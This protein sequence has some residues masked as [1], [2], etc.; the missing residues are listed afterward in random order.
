MYIHVHTGRDEK[1][2]KPKYTS[3]IIGDLYCHLY[4]SP[5][6]YICFGFYCFQIQKKEEK[7]G[8]ISTKERL[9]V[10][11]SVYGKRASVVSKGV[12]LLSLDMEIT[13]LWSVSLM[14]KEHLK[15]S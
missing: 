2:L 11:Y 8:Q 10:N 7:N 15:N 1:G 13:G 5:Y 4:T 9:F 3:G 14:A 6:F 12:V